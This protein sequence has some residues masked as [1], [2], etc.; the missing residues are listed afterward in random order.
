ME[1]L[2]SYNLIIEVSLIIIISFIFNGISKKTNVPSVLMLIIL[3]VGLQYALNYF[4][5]NK[6]N[7]LPIL[8]V[9][10]IVGLIMIVLEAALELELKREKLMPIL[11]SM[12]IALIGLIASAWIAAL[13]L[14]EFIP[15][16]DH[17]ISMVI[18]HTIIHT[19][20]RH[21]YTECKCFKR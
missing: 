2:S 8:E 14:Y 15:R 21:Y 13:I 17:A 20:K 7:F 16:N 12:A 1:I 5:S 18:C 10:G 11:K 4:S 19:F 9:L 3:G 6:L